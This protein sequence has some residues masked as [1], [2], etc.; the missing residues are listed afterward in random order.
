SRP[1]DGEDEALFAALE[2]RR[3]LWL[4]NKTDLP[5]AWEASALPN[6]LNTLSL[7]AKTDGP[8]ALEAALKAVLCPDE[9]DPSAGVIANERQLDC[10][11]QAARAVQEA[12]TALREGITLDAVGVLLQDALSALAA[13]T[14]EAVSETVIEDVFRRFCVGK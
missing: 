12:R 6:G 5:A 4:I 10:A 13:L 8:D 7:S 1:L 14:G 2:G 11:R 9:I 3:A